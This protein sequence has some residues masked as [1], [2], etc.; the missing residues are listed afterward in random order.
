[1]VAH[2]RRDWNRREALTA[3]AGAAVVLG[4]GWWLA[5]ARIHR[6]SIDA[7]RLYHKGLESRDQ[8]LLGSDDQAEAYFQQAVDADPQFAP[9][10]GALAL[11]LATSLDFAEEDELT[12]TAERSRAAAAEALELNSEQSDAKAALALIPS[13]FRKWGPVQRGIA[14]AL[15]KDQKNPFLM[16]ALSRLHGDTGQWN[17]AVMLARAT[18]RLQPLV[19][20]AVGMLVYSLWSAGRIIEAEAE[21]HR[22]LDRWPRNR[23]TWFAHLEFLTYTGRPEAAVEFAHD[24][25]HL[26]SGLDPTRSVAV[27]IARALA[28]G[29]TS[30]IKRARAMLA[31]L[32]AKDIHAAHAASWF[33]TAIGAIDEAFTLLDAYL[34][35]RGPMAANL[36]RKMH[37]LARV[38]TACL[39]DAPGRRL[40]PDPR[41][42][43]L[44]REIGLDAYWLS[45]R[46]N[47][48]HLTV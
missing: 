17:K 33:L 4:G 14:D 39:F 34:L 15:Q 24:R 18:V 32:V 20:E 30:D 48:P 28:T 2:P 43:K 40:W 7:W 47:P 31:E 22:A 42:P 6:P 9:A 1:V 25:D 35:R 27:A 26:P 38:P 19:P 16:A 12:A 23:R 29:T 5:R 3:A 10:W 46:F 21:S 13:S 45:I 44:T 36:P 37:P 41:F 8:T 11:A